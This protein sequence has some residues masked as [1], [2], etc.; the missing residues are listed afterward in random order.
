VRYFEGLGATVSLDGRV[1]TH[2]VVFARVSE[3][4]SSRLEDGNVSTNES[5]HNG[6][7]SRV[8][9]CSARNVSTASEATV[10]WNLDRIDQV[11][12]PL[13]GSYQPSYDGEGVHVFVI[14]SGVNYAHDEFAGQIGDGY[15]FIDTDATPEDCNGHGSHVSALVLGKQFG[16]AKRATLHPLRV[17]GCDGHGLFSDVVAALEWVG[18]HSARIKVATLSLGGDRNDAANAAVDA[19]HAQGVMIVVSAGNDGADACAVSPASAAGS[20]AVGMFDA[21]DVA[22]DVSNA[23][24]CV[25]ILGPGVA[26]KSAWIGSSDAS[27]L[28]SGTSMAAPHVAGVLAQIA[29]G[30]ASDDDASLSTAALEAEL[31]YAA[32]AGAISDS[33]Q[34]PGRTVPNLLLQVWRRPRPPL[35][36]LPSPSPAPP[37]MPPDP[38]GDAADSTGTISDVQVNSLVGIGVGAIGVVAFALG[39]V[40][41]SRRMRHH[42]SRNKRR[43]SALAPGASG[44]ANAA[45]AELHEP[46]G[47]DAVADAGERSN[48]AQPALRRGLG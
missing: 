5:L 11:S 15:D 30:T 21:L 18:A 20:L 23:G 40:I 42:T 37:G 2:D 41:Y 10:S 35:M 27:Q 43:S 22:S 26:V 9:P 19:L 34:N 4:S 45:T 38:A 12:L 13:D 39:L 6:G 44:R 33:A 1:A 7:R 16:V 28:L 29:A 3:A 14:D 24:A 36:Q 25:G 17:L 46:R 32:V 48:R 31:V 47:E 8:P